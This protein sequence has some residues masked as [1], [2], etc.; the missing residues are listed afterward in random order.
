M[1]V[2]LR[3]KSEQLTGLDAEKWLEAAGI[4]CNKNGVP[5][6]TRPP[7][8]TS[9]IRL[10]T[11]AVTTRGLREGEMGRIAGWIDAVLTAGVKGEAERARAAAEVREQVRGLCAE[12]P[13]P[14][15]ESVL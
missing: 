15:R 9:G 13:I 5:Q 11:P 3:R 14:S 2:D 8:L 4:I 7:K 10:G 12:F 6:D 1:L